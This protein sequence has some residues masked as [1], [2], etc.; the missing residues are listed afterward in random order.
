MWIYVWEW[1]FNQCVIRLLEPTFPEN[2]AD[3]PKDAEAPEELETPKEPETPNEPE[4][5]KEPESAKIPTESSPEP[6]PESTT[7]SEPMSDEEFE[8]L[9]LEFP[10]FDFIDFEKEFGNETETE[11][12]KNTEVPENDSKLGKEEL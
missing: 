8:K 11:N 10:D 7:E 1:F 3:A 9:K 6:S 5:P 4:T 2:D 12:N